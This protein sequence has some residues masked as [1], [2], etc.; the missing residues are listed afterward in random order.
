MAVVVAA[1]VM[2]LWPAGARGGRGT[3]GG[4]PGPTIGSVTPDH[5]PAEGGTHV[6]VKGSYFTPN[7]RVTFGGV[8]AK[9]V[10]V[11]AQGRITAVTPPHPPGRVAVTVGGGVRGLAFTYEA[12]EPK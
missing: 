6:T 10:V 2:A 8:E 7:S 4:P 12:S 3:G 9:D 11:V 5:G 1:A